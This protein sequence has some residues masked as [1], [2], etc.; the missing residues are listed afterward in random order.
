[1]T[2]P[3]RELLAPF[4]GGEP[5]FAGASCNDEDAPIPALGG[6]QQILMV[7]HTRLM[8]P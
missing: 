6:L 5:T 3:L 8:L 2:P 7:P 4:G 1:M